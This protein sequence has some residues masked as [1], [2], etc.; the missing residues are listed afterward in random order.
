M[1]APVSPLP[2]IQMLWIRGELS[3]LELLSLR[4]FLANG[5]PVH[6]YHYGPLTNVPAGVTLCDAREVLP[7]TCVP[8]QPAAPMGKASMTTF[9]NF[10]RYRLLFERGGWWADSD[11]VCTRPW[12][13]DA[14]A[15][16]ASTSE[17]SFGRI[18]NNCAMRFP[19]GHPVMAAC[20]ERCASLD[21]RDVP[22]GQTGPVL[23]HETITAQGCADLVAEPPVFCPV[24]WNATWQL[25]RP[26]W[27]RFTL[28]ELHQR[29]RRPHL[30]TRFTRDTV[31]VHL[32][33]EMWRKA[34][35]DKNARGPHSCLYEKLQRRWNP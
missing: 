5:H 8:T 30:S 17:G 14:A 16:T 12:R 4:S 9:S 31:A 24:P 27:R 11:V 15:I 10:F 34:G 18:A 35:R 19:A 23:V 6:L 33:N 22:W 29:L 3:R 32:W 28:G 21:P 26:T 7:E 20:A 1:V 2:P 13:F 25:L